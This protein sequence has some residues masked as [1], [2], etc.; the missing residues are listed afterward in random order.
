MEEIILLKYFYFIKKN[1]SLKKNVNIMKSLTSYYLSLIIRKSVIWGYPPTIMIEPTNICNLKCPLCPSGNGTLKRQKGYMDYSLFEKIIDEIKDK[2]LLV[3]LFN[4]GEAFLN[5]NFLKMIKYASDNCIYTHVVTNGNSMPNPEDII[6]SGI[7]SLTFSIDGITQ[8]TY[9]KYRKNGDLSKVLENLK[10]I[11]KAKKKLDS[12][13][14]FIKWQFIVMKHNEYEIEEAKK[15]ANDLGVD[16]FDLK[17]VQI[18]SKEDVNNFLPINPKYRRYKIK[19][20][21]FEMKY[22]I[23]NKCR[24]LWT[25]SVINWNGEMSICCFDK[26]NI[27]KI[28]NINNQS[29]IKLWKSNDFQR[30]R[31][32]ILKNRKDIPICNNC[33]EGIKLK[34][35]SI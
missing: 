33:S 19:G 34:I 9:N 1:L 8:E 35:K 28:G 11:I 27:Y 13:T 16:N 4:Q 23:K 17:T 7:N 5:R 2:I 3:L 29:I 12:K 32:Q 26:D 21:N 30:H 31:N 6:K 18:Y 20:E 24:N 25:Q 10:E 14:P 22:G 15:I